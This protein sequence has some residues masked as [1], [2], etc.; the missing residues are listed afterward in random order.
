L[1]ETQYTEAVDMWSVGCIFAEMILKRP[2]LT[3]GST[4]EQ[5]KL[6]LECLGMPNLELMPNLTI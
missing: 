1:G 2:I 5:L 4:R 3:A 6:I